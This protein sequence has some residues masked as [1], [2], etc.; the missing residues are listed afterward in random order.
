MICGSLRP[1]QGEM[2]TRPIISKSQTVEKVATEQSGSHFVPS[3][4]AAIQKRIER[5]NM[6]NPRTAF[7]LLFLTAYALTPFRRPAAEKSST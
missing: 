3:S 6:K 2:T 4:S 7:L 1:V 5:V